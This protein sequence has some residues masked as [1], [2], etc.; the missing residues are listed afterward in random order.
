M[1][2]LATAA[3]AAIAMTA[4]AVET[5]EPAHAVIP[6]FVAGGVGIGA[7]GIG[8]AAAGVLFLIL[9]GNN[10]IGV[11]TPDRNH[12]GCGITKEKVGGTGPCTELYNIPKAL[13]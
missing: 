6:P 9:D 13:R 1:R 11:T 10:L 2:K 12:D 8:L 7:A 3:A 5:T 4:V